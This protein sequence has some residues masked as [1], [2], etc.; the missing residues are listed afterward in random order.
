MCLFVHHAD[1][2]RTRV[3][4]EGPYLV[5]LKCAAAVSVCATH[6]LAL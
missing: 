2:L 1:L 6:A 3:N 4:M 5:F